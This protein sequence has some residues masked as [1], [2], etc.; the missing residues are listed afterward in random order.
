V[1]QNT[2]QSIVPDLATGWSWNEDGTELIFRLRELCDVPDRGMMLA[3]GRPSEA[4]ITV[5]NICSRE[6]W[7]LPEQLSI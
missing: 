7:G 2:L 4:A 3:P 6:L 1:P 5:C